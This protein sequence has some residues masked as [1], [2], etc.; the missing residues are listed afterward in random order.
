MNFV[1]LT[2]E[3]LEKLKL[4]G[5]NILRSNS[6]MTEEDPTWIPEKVDLEAFFDLDSEEVAKRSIPLQE[7]WLL[8]ID[9]GLMLDNKDLFGSVMIET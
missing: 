5:Y 4:Q 6:P 2:V 9:E 8:V 1:R 3:V 7:T